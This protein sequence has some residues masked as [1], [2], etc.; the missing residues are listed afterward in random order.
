VRWALRVGLAVVFLAAGASKLAGAPEAVE[1]FDDIGAGQPLRY[2]V[3]TLEL[4]GA[5]GLFVPRLTR[6]AALGLAALMVGATL[7]NVV[8][9]QVSPLL[10]VLLA[11][12]AIATAALSSPGS[13]TR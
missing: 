3:G 7:V 11:A 10:T 6:P 12:A 5:V 4:A 8:V 2:L 13:R 9:L 1:L